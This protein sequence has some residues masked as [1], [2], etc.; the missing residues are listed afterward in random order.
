MWITLTK[1]WKSKLVPTAGIEPATFWLQVSCTTYYAKSAFGLDER[2]W[3][4]DRLIPN[5]ELSQTKLHPEKWLGHL[6]SNQGNARF[7][8]WCLTTWLHPNKNM[9]DSEGLEPSTKRLTAVCSTYWATNPWIH[10][11]YE[12]VGKQA[13][14]LALFYANAV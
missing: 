12:Y 14:H 1:P 13:I 7:R 10:N 6:D 8:V 4:F 9:A 2:I 3:T 5:Q 11:I